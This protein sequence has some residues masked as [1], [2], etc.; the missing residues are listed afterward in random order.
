MVTEND[1]VHIADIN[2]TVPNIFFVKDLNTYITLSDIETYVI[3]T[4]I[5]FLFVKIT[6]HNYID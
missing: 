2:I 4:I 1:T 5:R 6:L 3:K